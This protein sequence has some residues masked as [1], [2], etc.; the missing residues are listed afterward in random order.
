MNSQWKK[1]LLIV[2]VLAL[3]TSGCAQMRGVTATNSTATHPAA[4]QSIFLFPD[5]PVPVELEQDMD[6]TMLIRTQR[7][8]GGIVVL[9]GRVTVSSLLDYFSKKLVE[10]G[11]QLVGSMTAKRSLLA[12]SKGDQGHCL[13]QIYETPGG[14]NTEVQIW[15]VE[16]MESSPQPPPPQPAPPTDAD[17]AFPPAS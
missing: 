4:A 10:N 11:W 16:P 7:F 8:Q 14:F 5:L 3:F 2:A 13:V 12:F 15:L 9:K 17:G 6:R 1:T